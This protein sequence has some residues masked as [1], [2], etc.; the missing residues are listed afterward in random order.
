MSDASLQWRLKAFD[1]LSRRELYAV[2]GARVAV[3]VVEQD[4]PYQEID[5]RDG[6]ALHLAAWTPD[7]SLAAYARILP[8]GTRFDQPS[9]GR[10]LTA[11][12]HR[13]TGLGQTLMRRAIAEARSRFPGD[14]IRIS[15]QCY[16]ERFYTG[17]GFRIDSDPY[18]EDGIPHVDMRLGPEGSGD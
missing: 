13:R 4:C 1:E 9:I 15:A 8:P 10:V 12:G 11:A 6:D 7:G 3:F 18:D 14:D 2:L 17:L 16:L 5:G